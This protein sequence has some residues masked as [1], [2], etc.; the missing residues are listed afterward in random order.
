MCANLMGYNVYNKECIKKV[1]GLLKD[2]NKDV[3]YIYISNYLKNII[4]KL[5]NFIFSI[6]F[7]IKNYII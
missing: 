1:I 4:I 5:Y 2:E 3:R 6:K 7:Y